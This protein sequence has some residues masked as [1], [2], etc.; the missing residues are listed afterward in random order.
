LNIYST[1]IYGTI[2]NV[3]TFDS[4]IEDFNKVKAIP[5]NLADVSS[6]IF[7]EIDLQVFD[8][9]IKILN[10]EYSVSQIA[11]DFKKSI[12]QKEIFIE[13]GLKI[14][15]HEEVCPFCGQP[16]NEAAT[17]LIDQYV[18]FSN[19][20]ETKTIKIINNK[21][22]LLNRIKLNLSDFNN[23]V[24]FQQMSFDNLKSNYIPSYSEEHLLEINIAEL[25][26]II[27]IFIDSLKEKSKAVNVSIKIKDDAVQKIENAN[28]SLSLIV[29]TNNELVKRINDRKSKISDENKNI[30]KDICCSAY[31]YIATTLKDKISERKKLLEEYKRLASAIKKKKLQKR[32]E[33]SWIIFSR[34]SILLIVKTFN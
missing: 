22:E 6:V 16:Y 14:Y 33:K 32:Y 13:S 34:E 15:T 11:E 28:K 19:D 9:I 8:E 27:D 3:K 30:R 5:E 25:V 4:V 7:P 26:A 23:K 29:K 1:Q 18:L 12:Q 20:I 21:I 24:K 2:P 10:Y 17:K 31:N